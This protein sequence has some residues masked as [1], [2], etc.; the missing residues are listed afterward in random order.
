MQELNVEERIGRREFTSVGAPT[1]SAALDR[2]RGE[3]TPPPLLGA[4]VS[5]HWVGQPVDVLASQALGS[6]HFNRPWPSPHSGPHLLP[7]SEP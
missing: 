7:I 1:G 5:L 3:A 6:D 2:E 4:V